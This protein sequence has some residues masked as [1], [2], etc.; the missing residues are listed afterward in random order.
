MAYGSVLY[1]TYIF[2]YG[3][4]SRGQNTFAP[5]LLVPLICT[6]G[7][8]CEMVTFENGYFGSWSFFGLI[9]QLDPQILRYQK[10]WALDNASPFKHGHFG[11]LYEIS[12]KVSF[13]C[14][15]CYEKSKKNHPLNHSNHVANPQQHIQGWPFTTWHLP[16]SL[17][18]FFPQR[19]HQTIQPSFDQ[20]D[21]RF[22]EVLLNLPKSMKN[23]R[24]W[25]NG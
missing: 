17:P 15:F 12:G 21:L 24:T 9:L 25:L 16:E 19:I 13:F 6:W 10:W 22:Q 2:I 8:T 11:Y 7:Y 3:T 1:C 4:S 18:I 14:F 5:L 20:R 23:S